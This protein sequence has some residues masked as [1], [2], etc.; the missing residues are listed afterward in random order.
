M[1]EITKEEKKA[2]QKVVESQKSIEYQQEVAAQKIIRVDEIL[3]N[4]MKK[5]LA[6][7]KDVYE[8]FGTY[9]Y[10]LNDNGCSLTPDTHKKLVEL[11]RSEGY[12]DLAN[13]LENMR[14][15]KLLVGSKLPDIQ[16]E[17]LKILNRIASNAEKIY[18]QPYPVNIAKDLL[19][20]KMR[21]MLED[22][23]PF[24]NNILQKGNVEYPLNQ[25]FFYNDRVGGLI[26]SGIR[27]KRELVRAWK[28]NVSPKIEALDEV[29]E[30]LYGLL[31][32]VAVAIAASAI[33]EPARQPILQALSSDVLNSYVVPGFGIAIGA[34][35]FT[36][37]MGYNFMTKGKNMG[38]V[39]AGIAMLA[40]NTVLSL[41]TSYLAGAMFGQPVHIAPAAVIGAVTSIAVNLPRIA[42][43][44]R[45]RSKGSTIEEIKARLLNPPKTLTAKEE[46][47]GIYK[48]MEECYTTLMEYCAN[49]HPTLDAL[50]PLDKGDNVQPLD[51]DLDLDITSKDSFDDGYR[52]GVVRIARAIVQASINS[53]E[54]K[55]DIIG[56]EKEEPKEKK[57]SRE[58]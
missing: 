38:E 34:A 57:P 6:K 8:L 36:A 26:G 23:D 45:N 54:K 30:K 39:K 7:T 24:K 9:V 35:A 10:E 15:F 3:E 42:L 46:K 31:R 28:R 58:L 49:I 22:T 27:K 40:I 43:A 1:Q 44:L 18:D 25:N 48:E 32:S 12:K 17:P 11:A 55:V 20:E 4:V 52:E 33:I 5:K 13:Q 21:N 56:N 19:L 50:D 16:N 2:Y 29:D 14:V 51:I 53:V 41:G 47:F 37:M